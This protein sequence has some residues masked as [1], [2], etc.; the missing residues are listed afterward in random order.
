MCLTGLSGLSGLSGVCDGARLVVAPPVNA[1]VSGA[2]TAEADGKYTPRG[3]SGNGKP[4]YNLEGQ[5]DSE[6][7]SAITFNSFGGGVWQ[8]FDA[9]G[10]ALYAAQGGFDFPWLASPWESTDGS[11]DP[12]PTVTEV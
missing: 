12:P 8:L 5:P 9:D 4:F 10:N 2:G 3:I 7:N 11:Y 1:L 6:D